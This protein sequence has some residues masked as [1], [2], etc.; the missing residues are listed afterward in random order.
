[1]Q[2]GCSSDENSQFPV[3]VGAPKSVRAE[4]AVGGLTPNAPNCD[5]RLLVEPL[6][7]RR[8]RTSS[9]FEQPQQ[10]GEADLAHAAFRCD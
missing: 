7:K 5:P 1:M 2:R 8:C 6:Q 4:G 10:G 3:S 9:A